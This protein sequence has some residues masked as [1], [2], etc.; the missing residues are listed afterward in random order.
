[1]VLT[2]DS[3]S[4]AQFWHRRVYKTYVLFITQKPMMAL[5]TVKV[6]HKVGSYARAFTAAQ[7]LVVAHAFSGSFISRALSLISLRYFRA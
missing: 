6:T 5:I 2:L 7:S 4:D 3:E 1:M